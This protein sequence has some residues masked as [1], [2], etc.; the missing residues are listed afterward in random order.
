MSSIGLLHL[1]R[2][3]LL[4]PSTVAEVVEIMR[5]HPDAPILAG[6][7][8]TVAA[9][10]EK[11]IK[12]SHLID[13][14]RVG[15]LKR[16][17]IGKETVVVGALTTHTTLMEAFAD[18]FQ[19]FKHFAQ[20]YTS[21]AVANMATVGG[22]LALKTSTEDLITVLLVHDATLRIHKAE[23]VVEATLDR[24]LGDEHGRV[25]IEEVKFLNPATISATFEKIALGISY[26]PLISAAVRLE[27]NEK[28]GWI[29]RIATSHRRGEIPGRIHEAESIIERAGPSDETIA[30]AAEAVMSTIDPASDLMAPS[31]Y[32]K[33]VASVLVKR[34]LLK[35]WRGVVG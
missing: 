1:P 31:W 35:L 7:T 32:R 18:R 16:F 17:E 9:M 34:H 2:F 14:S 30:R 33:R 6:G 5:T 24:Y 15:A 27:Q 29:C 4:T 20:S 11:R 28:K 3:K 13:I 8:H 21:P 23:G 19:A 12:P 25:L 22:S 10:I 26:I